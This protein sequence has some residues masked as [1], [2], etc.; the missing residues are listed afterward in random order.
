MNM[1]LKC[2]EIDHEDQLIQ[3]LRSNRQLSINNGH[4]V[5][6]LFNKWTQ[7]LSVN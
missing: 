6:T 5:L 2:N 4:C 1:L 7:I 3:F